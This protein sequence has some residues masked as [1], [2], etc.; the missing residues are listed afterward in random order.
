MAYNDYINCINTAV[1]EAVE[2]TKQETRKK[3]KEDT[4]TEIATNLLKENASVELVAK[5]TGWSI[6]KVE[7]LKERVFETE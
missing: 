4:Q 1:E 2:K 3:T 7:E 5:V 6:E